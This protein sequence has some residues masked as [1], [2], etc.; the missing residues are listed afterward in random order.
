MKKFRSYDYE[1]EPEEKEEKEEPEDTQCS[2]CQA[3]FGK[4]RC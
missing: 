2:I 4:C 3:V 1:K